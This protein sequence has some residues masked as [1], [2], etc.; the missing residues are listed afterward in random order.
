MDSVLRLD[1]TLAELLDQID[2]EVGLGKC[3]VVLTADHGASPLPERILAM[4]RGIPAGR[5]DNAAIDRLVDAAMVA[6][7]G[8]APDGDFWC[9]RD[10][11][12]YTLHPSALKARGV[13][14]RRAESVVKAALLGYPAIAAVYTAEELGEPAEGDSML[15]MSR[16]S[17][18][19]GRSTDV[20]FVMKPYFM[21]RSPFGTNHG[22]PWDY[23]THVPLV[24]FGAGVPRGL[25]PEAV[26]VEDLAPTLSALLGIPRPPRAR[27]R[28][29][30]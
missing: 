19:P 4:N 17:F 20:E 5:L 7:F 16:R 12:G 24:W 3:V 11:F 6:A 13:D 28:Q 27:G 2:K 25:H 1:R 8:P 30:F 18:H 29:L 15:A 10:N 26:A 21:D 23:D 9:R 14:I 22:T